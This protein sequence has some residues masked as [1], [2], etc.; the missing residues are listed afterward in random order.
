MLRTGH[1]VRVAAG[2]SFVWA[3]LPPLV[4]TLD[5][6]PPDAEVLQ[7]RRVGRSTRGI[8][9]LTNLRKLWLHKA[10]QSTVD[11]LAG[12]SSLEV[13]SIRGLSATSLA[14]LRHLEKLRQLVLVDGNRVADLDWL[15]ALPSLS[16]LFFEG[17]GSIRTLGGLPNLA[18]LQSFGFEGGMDRAVHLETLAP[19][20]RA[21]ALH[22]LFLA[23]TR[24]GDKS[25]APLHGLKHLERLECRMDFPDRE[26]LALRDAVPG[27]ECDWIRL[28]ETHG[29][30]RAGR[31]AIRRRLEGS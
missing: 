15:K 29:S 5:S 12:V 1:D 4:E 3:T 10:D 18:A 6:V 28:I 25:L 13:L 27:I 24:V 14:P 8:D 26:F 2:V 16:A 17:F 9:R 23:N 19:L 30:L 7:L 31:A 22:S 21:P 20:V 11:A